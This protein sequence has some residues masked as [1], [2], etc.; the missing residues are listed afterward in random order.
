MA[1]ILHR[2][3]TSTTHRGG[4]D[5]QPRSAGCRSECGTGPGA[6]RH[7]KSLTVAIGQCHWQRATTTDSRLCGGLPGTDEHQ[8]LQCQ[9]RRRVLGN[10]L[11]RP[12]PQPQGP[13]LG[14]IL[15]HGAGPPQRADTAGVFGGRRVS[16]PG[17]GSG[18]SGR[19]GKHSCGT[20]GHLQ[21]G[22]TAP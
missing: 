22:Q 1:G 4:F 15:C 21:H 11:L 9:S 18:K 3:K 14:G 7:S 12:H 6:V 8:E 17:C 10:R 20:E 19:G 5:E 16:D 13:S 2:R